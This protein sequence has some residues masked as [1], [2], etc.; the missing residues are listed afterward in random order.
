MKKRAF[1]LVYPAPSFGGLLGVLLAMWYAASSQNNAAAY[2]LLFT[3]TGVALISIPHTALNLAGL[4]L[5]AQSAKPVFAGDEVSLPVEISNEARAP[6]HGVFVSL[7][8]T[9]RDGERVDNIAP[10][11]AVR[12]MIRFPARRRGE[13]EVGS[14]RLATVYPLGFMRALKRL[15]SRQRYIVYPKPAGD[16]KLPVHHARSAHTARGPER[17]EGDDF[18]G[19]RTYIPGESQRHID[20]RAVARG[21]ALMTKQYA[22]EPGGL[23]Y[24]D[25]ASVR[26]S[27]P[28]DRLS[29]LALWVIE[30]E[31]LRRP[32]GLRLPGVHIAPFRGAAHFHQCLRALALF[33]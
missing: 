10:G 6:R 15:P 1:L 31:R 8:D 2:L 4:K 22:A 32:Y 16:P 27:D 7:P 14:L 33:K 30:A 13:H 23:L 3:L 17:G 21:Q 20:W 25:F 26:S 29:Q 24:L 28:E 5:T 12:L 11:K 19:V 9:G 18:A